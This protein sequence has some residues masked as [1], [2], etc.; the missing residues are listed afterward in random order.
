MPSSERV[1][2][3]PNRNARRAATAALL[4]LLGALA[5]PARG[6]GP[7][8]LR[9]PSTPHRDDGAL[10]LLSLLVPMP[11]PLVLVTPAARTR[12]PEPA[13]DPCAGPER[14]AACFAR[15]GAR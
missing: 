5:L 11:L 10:L 3:P 12:S 2:Q 1:D 6:E 14:T 15:G 4:L 13:E 8:K 9:T 7:A